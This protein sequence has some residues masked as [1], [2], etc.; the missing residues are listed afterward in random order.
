[1]WTFSSRNYRNFATM[2]SSTLSL[3]T[4]VAERVDNNKIIFFLFLFSPT[5]G[6]NGNNGARSW[7]AA[8]RPSTLPAWPR[9]R[10]FTL[11]SRDTRKCGSR[12]IIALLA[13]NTVRRWPIVQAAAGVGWCWCCFC[14]LAM[15]RRA[16]FLP[17]AEQTAATASGRRT[18]CGFAH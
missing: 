15:I 17:P 9:A 12:I 2:C 16:F 4:Q 3:H 8:D 14:W 11:L 18:W 6:P 10:L 5:A 13:I 1:M 7:A